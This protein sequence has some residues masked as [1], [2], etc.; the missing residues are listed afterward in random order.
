MKLKASFECLAFLLVFVLCCSVS[1][2]NPK[3]SLE[4]TSYK[5][6][7][8]SS[9]MASSILEQTAQPVRGLE[10]LSL[11]KAREQMFFTAVPIAL[12]ILHFLL[13]VFYP[14]SIEN[15]YYS[16][17]VV[18]MGLQNYMSYLPDTVELFLFLR[19]FVFIMCLFGLLFAYTVVYSKIQKQFFIFVFISVFMY[20]WMLIDPRATDSSLFFAYIIV[21]LIEFVRTIVSGILKKIRGMWI[22]GGGTIIVC[23]VAVYESLM[24]ILN[25]RALFGVEDPGVYGTLVFLISMSAYLSWKFARTNISLEKRSKELQQLNIELEDRVA[26]RTKELAEANKILEKQ[27]LDLS[28]SRNEIQVAHIE[29]LKAHEELNQTQARLVQSEK[30]ASLGTMAAGVAHEINTP[31]GAVSSASDTS[32]RSIDKV[33]ETIEE[34]RDLENIKK[35][36]KFK[37]ALENLKNNN[38]V[39]VMASE[40]ITKIVKSLRS[41]TRLDEAE[42]KEADIHE[43]L[44]STLT[45]LHHKTK[46]R[47]DIVK[48]YGDLPQI[49]CYPHRLNQVFMNILNN[50]SQAIP[51][52]GTIKIETS[53]KKDEV[54]VKII[55]DG[56]G[57]KK[58]NLKKIFDPG[59]TTRGVGVG[60]GLGLSI[61]YNIIKDHNGEIKVKSEEGKGTEVIIILP[62]KQAEVK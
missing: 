36:S 39:I 51:E 20:S 12:A 8:L 57:I 60:T 14:R 22:I 10:P 62:I 5:R 2:S 50:A 3:G 16:F 40:R 4:L 45:L 37:L 11:N 30:M 35:D 27:N 24:D 31:V 41:F 43:G 46:D 49:Q 47:V 7:Q 38:D 53:K 13:F 32:R 59:F 26:Q 44:D 6:I 34:G 18:F 52:K 48:D 23:T 55:D 29:L 1:V 9:K 21:F 61:S 25:F 54:Y 33:I 28:E 17:F 58:E 19:L 15:L 42:F 56:E